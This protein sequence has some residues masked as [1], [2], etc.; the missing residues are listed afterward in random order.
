MSIPSCPLSRLLLT[1]DDGIDAPGLRTM[2]AVLASG[3]LLHTSGMNVPFMP[4]ARTA[5]AH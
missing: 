5:G 4:S 1:N 2:T 3:D